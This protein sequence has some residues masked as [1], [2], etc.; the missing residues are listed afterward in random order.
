MARERGIDIVEQISPKKGDFG[1]LVHAE[2]VTDKKT[3]VAAG[4]LFGNQFLRLA[5]P[6][7]ETVKVQ[8]PGLVWVAGRRGSAPGTA[9][10][11]RLRS[12]SERSKRPC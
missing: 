8:T 9:P 11:G 3:Y 6:A 1:T 5:Q 4:T 10:R 7:V 12:P 2:V